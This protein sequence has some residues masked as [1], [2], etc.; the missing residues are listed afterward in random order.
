MKKLYKSLKIIII[1][2]ITQNCYAQ[3]ISGEVLDLK[4]KKPLQN[5]NI[6]LTKNTKTGTFTNAD[7]KFS[8]ALKAYKKTDSITFSLIGYKKNKTII[9]SLKDKNNTILL[10]K[11]TDSLKEVTFK[12]KRKQNFIRFKKIGDIKSNVSSFGSVLIDD[13]IYITG[14]DKSSKEEPFRRAL[15]RAIEK[16]PEINYFHIID[17]WEPNGTI[18]SYSKELIIYNLKNNTRKIIKDKLQQRAYHQTNFYNGNLYVLGGKKLNNFTSAEFLENKI[19]IYNLNNNRVQIDKTNPHKASNFAS[20]IYKGNIITIGGSVAIK[21]NG[22]KVFSNKV[23]QYNIE[24]GYWFLIEKMKTAKE[25]SGILLNDKIYLIG[26]F[27]N[28]SLNTIESWNLLSGKWSNEGKLFSAAAKPALTSNE[29]TIYIF[30]RGELIRYNVKKKTLEKYNINLN[31]KNAE[32]H[33]YNNCLYII[34][35]KTEINFLEAP[36]S[37]LFK[38]DISEFNKTKMNDFKKL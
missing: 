8:L 31:L 27:N 17:N 19:E 1:L 15:T 29:N 26:G 14:G 35:G 22:L 34:G 18:N 7:G 23:H 20:F 10:T 37:M 33:F 13:K 5:V 25:V 6:Y 24:T 21:K 4:T 32:M 16:Y 12:T 11:K 28:K 38:I 36:S 9:L 3:N 30:N 2:I